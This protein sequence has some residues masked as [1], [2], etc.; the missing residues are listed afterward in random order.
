MSPTD[1]ECQTPLV[2]LTAYTTPL[3]AIATVIECDTDP[4]SVRI[5][6][7]NLRV[8]GQSCLA[9]PMH[10]VHI[11]HAAPTRNTAIYPQFR[12]PH[13]HCAIIFP[14]NACHLN[15]CHTLIHLPQLFCPTACEDLSTQ[16][17]SWQS[18]GYCHPTYQF[19][20]YSVKDYWCPKSCKV[21]SVTDKE[22]PTA[23]GP[24]PG[25]RPV[26]IALAG[27]MY[28]ICLTS[29]VFTTTGN[30]AWGYEVNDYCP[31]K[32]KGCSCV[33][34]HDAEKPGPAPKPNPAPVPAPS[35]EPAPEPDPD[36]EPA[37]QS[38]VGELTCC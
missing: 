21:C 30:V 35:L 22:Q 23:S 15:C 16:C 38:P 37:V 20:S 4:I 14:S 13:H 36:P 6:A 28:P 19:K 33:V 18:K 3:L 27:T 34:L 24:T 17:A 25:L 9:T 1:C 32:G 10:T 29:K 8:V 26:T 12:V 7:S 31:I 5:V 11:R 2:E